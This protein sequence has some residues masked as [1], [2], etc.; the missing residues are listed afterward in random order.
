M[1]EALD[2]FYWDACI[3][4]EHL[5][6]ENADA[7]KKQAI[8]DLLDDN[9]AKR[10]RL[11]TSVITHTEILPRKLGP[12]KERKYWSQFGS[13]YFFDIEIDRSVINLAREIKDFY[14]VEGKDGVGHKMM[15]TG[16]AIHLAT[17]ILNNATAFHTRD[18][19]R[20]GGNVPLI[21][22]DSSS[23]HGKICGKYELRIMSPIASQIR[24]DL[25]AQKKPPKA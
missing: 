25:D 23:P 20:R 11:C 19:K 2:L 9:E 15:S 8:T 5:R 7:Y 17:A 3:F 4:Y 13:L 10:N 14:Y 12:A 21:G 22:L 6:E 1:A 16:D 18:N 24:L